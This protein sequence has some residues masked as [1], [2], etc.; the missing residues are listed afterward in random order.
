MPIGLSPQPGPKQV[1]TNGP[2]ARTKNVP[3]TEKKKH[4]NQHKDTHLVQCKLCERSM[5]R[6]SHARPKNGHH[7][8][9]NACPQH[10]ERRRTHPQNAHDAQCV[11]F[12]HGL[13]LQ[14]CDVFA[15]ASTAPHKLPA[16]VMLEAPTPPTGA[17]LH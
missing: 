2:P 17:H 13:R 8:D 15:N 1:T 12:A 9:V 3:K 4:T 10:V 7:R 14:Q 5:W 16:T 11:V 6:Q